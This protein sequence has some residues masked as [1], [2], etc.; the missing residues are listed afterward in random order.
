MEVNVILFCYIKTNFV[1]LKNILIMGYNELQDTIH[2][3]IDYSIINLYNIINY[4][5]III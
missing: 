4:N 1:F 2:N 3:K 5:I